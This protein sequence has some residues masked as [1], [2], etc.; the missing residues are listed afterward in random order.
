MKQYRKFTM[1]LVI[2]FPVMC[3]L[4]I[5][6]KDDPIVPVECASNMECLTNNDSKDWKLTVF[7]AIPTN[8]WN[9]CMKDLVLT[10]RSNGSWGKLCPTATGGGK[11]WF[12]DD[13]TTITTVPGFSPIFHGDSAV[14]E[15]TMLN[16]MSFSYK[17]IYRSSP[18]NPTF[19]GKRESFTHKP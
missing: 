2:S 11:W 9:D 6:C 10:I 7:E 8:E 4:L 13:E 1:L 17:S 12:N 19:L 14:Y 5:S 18:D 15:I 3:F 16:D